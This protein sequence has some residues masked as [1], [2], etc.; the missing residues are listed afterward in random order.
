[1]IA[2][3]PASLEMTNEQPVERA[4][5]R[6]QRFA[7]KAKPARS[8]MGVV[9]LKIGLSSV[10]VIIVAYTGYWWWV[11]SQEQMVSPEIVQAATKTDAPVILDQLKYD[12]KDDKGRPY[13]IL[14]ESA[15]HPQNDSKHI[16]MV[17][18]SADMIMT[19]GAYVAVK[20]DRGLLDRDA[21]LVTLEGNVYVAH[22]S[23]LAFET[24]KAQIDLKTKVATGQV[25]VEGQNRDG[26]LI[27]EGF[28][29]LDDGR[30]IQFTGHA[31]LKLYGGQSKNEGQGQ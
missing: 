2:C 17:K 7:P 13:T 31:Y 9:A 4:P 11:H 10:A 23:G 16:S 6:V 25:P 29:I 30:V 1:M 27:A 3:V 24:E 21:N 8:R 18:P 19:G 26:E 15:S 22:D 12:G 20:A 5:G 28:R 14:A